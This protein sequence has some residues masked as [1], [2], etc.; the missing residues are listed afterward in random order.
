MANENE[1]LARQQWSEDNYFIMKL[2]PVL[3]W[4]TLLYAN[5]IFNIVISV[6][7]VITDGICYIL[8]ELQKHSWNLK[9]LESQKG[10]ILQT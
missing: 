6:V 2:E 10:W 1:D 9:I 7:K 8:V 4:L 5:L 3:C